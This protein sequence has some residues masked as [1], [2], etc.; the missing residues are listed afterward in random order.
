MEDAYDRF[1]AGIEQPV[2]RHEIETLNRFFGEVIIADVSPDRHLFC[3]RNG[4]PP[5]RL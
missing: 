3:V 4:S 2:A 5:L 1:V